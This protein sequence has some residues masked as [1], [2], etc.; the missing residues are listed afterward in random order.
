MT[1]KQTTARSIE[2]SE[3]GARLSACLR[4]F[5]GGSLIAIGMTA[6]F[7]A[8]A[9]KVSRIAGTITYDGHEVA[10]MACDADKTV[11][12]LQ[13]DT[14]SE[15]VTALRRRGAPE[16]G[17][18]YGEVY[19]AAVIDEATA[20]PALSKNGEQRIRVVAIQ[21]LQPGKNCHRVPPVVRKPPADV[22]SRAQRDPANVDADAERPVSP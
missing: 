17:F 8:S 15:S 20:A 5:A 1:A 2:H 13:D 19:G 4:V 18:W 9:Q 22:A 10:L 14:A 7:S 12:I 3:C 11:Y 21:N 6:A 16:Q